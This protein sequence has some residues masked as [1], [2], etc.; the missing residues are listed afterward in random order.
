MIA[1]LTAGVVLAVAVIFPLLLVVLFVGQN[2]QCVDPLRLISNPGN[3]AVI[4][5]LDV[6][7]R[8]ITDR[9]G[10]TKAFPHLREILPGRLARNIVPVQQRL[11]GVRVFLPELPEF[12]FADYSQGVSPTL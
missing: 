9:V 1:G 11:F 2:M 6:K 5:S 3:Q 8:T 12:P 7:N 10:V 4:V